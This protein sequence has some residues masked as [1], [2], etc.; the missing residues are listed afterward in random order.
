V[1]MHSQTM[2][3]STIERQ[4]S[5]T[6]W[7]LFVAVALGSTA[8]YAA[9]TAAPLVAREIG[10]S[11]A[12]S[13]VPGAASI[14][15]TALGS[16]VLSWVMARRGRRAGLALGWAI[17]VFGGVVAAIAV[18]ASAFA[19]L[20][21]AMALIGIG[22]AATQ[23]SRFAA[24]D[25]HPE[26]RRPLILGWV[27]WASTIGAALGPSLLGAGRAAARVFDAT[28]L[29]G[30]FVIV[31]VFYVVALL[32][33]EALRPDPT[34]LAVDD[35]TT[36]MSS[37]VSALRSSPHVRAALILMVVGQ[38]AMI[39]IMT[40]TP[41]HVSEH[42]HGLGV[43]GLVM[44]SHL[45]GMFAF[46]PPI[47][48][49]VGRIGSLKTAIIGMLLLTAAAAGAAGA[50]P[51]SSVLIGVSLFLLGLGWCFGFVAGSALLT[52]GLAYMARVRLQGSVD[53]IVWAFTAVASLSSGVLLATWSYA[54]LALIA[55]AI[56]V[57]TLVFTAT[58]RLRL[59]VVPA[60][61]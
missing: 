30:A 34:E 27:V 52:K 36:E 26:E 38:V 32:C 16:T 46:A 41:V 35:T 9:F 54:V 37:N 45:I 4:R 58:G 14:I 12:W 8:L 17:G 24:T 18:A 10:A 5:R 29:S 55:G 3:R 56:V 60:T 42:G 33:G 47:G 13:G 28:P 51:D 48:K 19:G 15:G 61:G 50:P 25:I 11:R 23:L 6:T 59:E 57:A 1:T 39:L 7:T 31:V 21:L 2:R 49:L 22:H 40:M 44:S 53:S 20:L 43:V